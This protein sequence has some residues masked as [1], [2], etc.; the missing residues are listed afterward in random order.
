MTNNFNYEYYLLKMNRYENS[1][2][3][4]LEVHSFY[5]ALQ[6][7]RYYERLRKI[8]FE[9]N[10]DYCNGYLTIE[11][12]DKLKVHLAQILIKCHDELEILRDTEY[13][14]SE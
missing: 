9:L 4:E 12:H 14:M 7:G 2:Y 3:Q 13:L 5:N 10:N 1:F 6:A 8:R 11:E